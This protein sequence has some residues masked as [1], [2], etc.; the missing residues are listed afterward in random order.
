[1]QCMNE[2]KNWCVYLISMFHF[3]FYNVNEQQAYVL[4]FPIQFNK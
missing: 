3:Y 4:Y 1:M 2:S